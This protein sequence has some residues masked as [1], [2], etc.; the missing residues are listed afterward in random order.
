MTVLQKNKIKELSSR[1][2]KLSTEDFE[3]EIENTKPK[4]GEDVLYPIKNVHVAKLLLDIL[5]SQIPCKR[6]GNCC[7]LR[8]ISVDSSEFLKICDYLALDAYKVIKKY[9]I[10]ERING[11]FYMYYI[12]GGPC[13]FLDRNEC[14]IYPVRPLTCSRYPAS[15]TVDGEI[16]LLNSSCCPRGECVKKLYLEFIKAMRLI[17]PKYM[18]DT[19]IDK[20]ITKSINLLK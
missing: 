1:M 7:R 6:C 17:N 10:T 19:E 15:E 11:A 4:K 16:V 12:K 9:K 20:H 8:D 13:A 2:D 14:S 18:K 3:M 5:D